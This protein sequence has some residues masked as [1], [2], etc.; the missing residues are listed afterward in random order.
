MLWLMASLPYGCGLR[1]TE[2]LTLRVKDIDFNYNQIVVRNGKGDKDR[3]TML[4]ASLKGAL[5]RHSEKVKKLHERDLKRGDGTAPL[6]YALTRKYPNAN[7]EFGR[8]YLF[9]SAI[10]WVNRIS[11]I[12]QRHHATEKSLQRTVKEAI[13]KAGI[14]KHGPRYS[15]GHTFRHSFATH[16]LE[17]GYD[18]RTV[19]ELLGHKDLN[20][21]MQYTHVLNKGGL[22]VR[23]PAGML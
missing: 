9:P 4:R 22:G 19:Q 2:C 12:K 5:Q 11:G 3:V 7:K 15:R 17:A 21:T 6:P 13:R 8:Q 10:L 20:T 18:I 16:L 1:L 14:N 23:S